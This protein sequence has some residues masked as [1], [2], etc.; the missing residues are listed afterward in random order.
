MSQTII[1]KHS[2][3]WDGSQT[4]W[5]IVDNSLDTP[6]IYN[7]ERSV[8]LHVDSAELK[9]AFLTGMKQSGARLISRAPVVPLAVTQCSQPD[10]PP[11]PARG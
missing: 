2:Y 1:Q 5:V 8:M 11:S 9:T 3:L 6:V 7:E 10:S 4:G